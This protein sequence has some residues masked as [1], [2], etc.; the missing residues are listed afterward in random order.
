[1]RKLL[2]TALVLGLTSAALASVQA[3]SPKP[4]KSPQDSE[5]KEP[6]EGD[7][8]FGIWQRTETGKV[9]IGTRI[10]PVPGTWFGWIVDYP[11]AEGTEITWREE[12]I[13]AG[14]P[15]Y[16]AGAARI[17]PNHLVR[18][19]TSTLSD[20][21]FDGEW[22]TDEWDPRGPATTRIFVEGR[23]VASFDFVLQ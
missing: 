14:A 18:Q 7:P 11:G 2:V 17:A 23:L 16:T 1:M 9:L 5:E 19:R 3:P 12:L 13:L 10:I 21:A 20:G 15:R 4:G 22:T 6:E 8:H